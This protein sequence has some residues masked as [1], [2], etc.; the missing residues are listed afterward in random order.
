MDHRFS[1]SQARI[2][3]ALRRNLKS[4]SYVRYMD[5]GL[6]ST[7]EPLEKSCFSQWERVEEEFCVLSISLKLRVWL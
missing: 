2:T 1:F 6:K 7:W 4:C 5:A 3:R